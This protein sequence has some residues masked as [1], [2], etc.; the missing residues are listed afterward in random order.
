MREQ[1]L[2]DN[3]LSF[4]WSYI[5]ALMFMFSIFT[6]T[7]NILSFYGS[8]LSRVIKKELIRSRKPGYWLTFCAFIDQD[9]Y[10]IVSKVSFTILSLTVSTFFNDAPE[11]SDD[12]KI[13]KK[14]TS[15]AKLG[16]NLI[17]L[18][19]PV[20]EQRIVT[21]FREWAARIM[22]NFGLKMAIDM[23]YNPRV[24]MIDDPTGKIFTSAIMMSPHAS[25][26][27][28]QFASKM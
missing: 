28:K 7:W 5:I 27:L 21:I 10:P 9:Q 8:R 3:H 13:W 20:I 12:S 16:A 18:M 24:L 14:S 26:Q 23:G 19:H 1:D 6:L 15:I 2:L 17:G 4:H 25:M 22:A 11:D